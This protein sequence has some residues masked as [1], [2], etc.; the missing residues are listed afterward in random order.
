MLHSCCPL[1]IEFK[2]PLPM[3][4]LCK[5]AFQAFAFEISQFTRCYTNFCDHFQALWTN[6]TLSQLNLDQSW[7]HIWQWWMD[8]IHVNAYR[9]KIKNLARSRTRVLEHTN[10][11]KK[12]NEFSYKTWFQHFQRESNV[13]RR[14]LL[15]QIGRKRKHRIM[16][17]VDTNSSQDVKTT[18]TQPFF[19][20]PIFIWMWCVERMGG[21]TFQLSQT[22]K[23]YI[24]L[25]LESF[26]CISLI[27]PS[28]RSPLLHRCGLSWCVPTKMAPLLP[29][30][31]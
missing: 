9:L 6:K 25:N 21:G 8:D 3:T 14:T 27:C 17:S 4:G 15:E 7:T 31:E 19:Q 13:I 2:G 23:D 11:K 28:I 12:K 1:Q 10:T 26:S 20:I 22:D 5:C 18:Q 30:Y 24:Q 29:H 16:F